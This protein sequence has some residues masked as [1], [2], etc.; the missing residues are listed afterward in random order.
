LIRVKERAEATTA[1]A[2]KRPKLNQS[3]ES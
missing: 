3:E 1:E 2:T